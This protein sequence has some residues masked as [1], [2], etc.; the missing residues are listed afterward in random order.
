MGFIV[1][2]ENYL[3]M[4]IERSHT[5]KASK[6]SQ[7]WKTE[8]RREWE[9]E[10]EIDKFGHMTLCQRMSLSYATNMKRN[11]GES[12]LYSIEYNLVVSRIL[13]FAGLVIWNIQATTERTE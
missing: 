10:R 6:K 13:S 9:R 8:R 4:E 3:K 1:L 7:I 11:S 5:V 2:H 12:G